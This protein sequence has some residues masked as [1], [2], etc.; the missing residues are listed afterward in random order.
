[1][2]ICTGV[3]LNP[4]MLEVARIAS[5]PEGQSIASLK[6]GRSSR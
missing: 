1:M 6:G 3:D 2:R 4:G 5:G